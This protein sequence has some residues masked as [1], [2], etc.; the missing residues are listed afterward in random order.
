MK[1][2]KLAFVFTQPPFGRSTSREGLDA[3]LAASAFCDE[4]DIAICFIDDGVFNL[5]A[6]QTPDL[7]LQKDHIAAFKLI[8]LYDLKHCFICQNAVADR[9]LEHSDWIFSSPI[10]LERAQITAVLQRAEKILTF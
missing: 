8:E 4:E 5:L 2:Y 6:H 10:F 7:I 9:H 1:T 3:L